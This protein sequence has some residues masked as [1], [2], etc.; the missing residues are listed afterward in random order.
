MNGYPCFM[1]ISPRLTILFRI[2]IWTSFAFYGHPC[3]DL[4]L[5]GNALSC[6]CK[7]Y[8]KSAKTRDTEKKNREESSF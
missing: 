6:F 8:L 3:I 4:L 1:D 2:P 7:M 5:I